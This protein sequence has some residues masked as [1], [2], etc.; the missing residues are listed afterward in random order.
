MAATAEPSISL[1][2]GDPADQDTGMNGAP[3]SQESIAA[4]RVDFVVRVFSTA[5]QGRRR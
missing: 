2:A 5:I 3:L 1:E 4:D